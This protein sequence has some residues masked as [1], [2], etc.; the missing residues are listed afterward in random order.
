MKI[1]GETLAKIGA[2]NINTPWKNWKTLA[3]IHGGT[4]AKSKQTTS[5]RH[6]LE[7]LAQ[8]YG[9]NPWRNPN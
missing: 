8:N 5:A 7:T 9:E 3:K 2:N 4:L 1:Y 6:E